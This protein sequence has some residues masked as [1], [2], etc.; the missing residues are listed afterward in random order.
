MALFDVGLSVGWVW[1]SVGGCRFMVGFVVWVL[2]FGF[3][4]CDGFVC[5]CCLFGFVV[6]G[7]I[8]LG[9]GFGFGLVFW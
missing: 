4:V 5:F 6:C 3:V 2:L 1:V 7:C 9:V 8:G